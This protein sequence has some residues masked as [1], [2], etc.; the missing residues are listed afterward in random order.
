MFK[1]KKAETL[2]K[3][4]IKTKY[5]DFQILFKLYSIQHKGRALYIKTDTFYCFF[6]SYTRIKTSICC[7]KTC[8]YLSALILA[9][10]MWQLPMMP[11]A[12]IHP[13]T[14]TEVS[15]ELSIE[16]NVDCP[17]PPYPGGLDSHYFQ[18]RSEMRTRQTTGQISRFGSVLLTWAE[19]ERSGQNLR[20]FLI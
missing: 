1:A 9:L 10:Q 7:S 18:N 20:T 2:C 4:W 14:I 17:F 19:V 16:K 11:W 12:L 3:T 13:H 5:F 8:M 6:W 15:F